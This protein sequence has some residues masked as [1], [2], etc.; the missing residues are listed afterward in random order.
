MNSLLGLVVLV[1]DI[2]ALI[3]IFQS[4]MDTTRK[5]IWTIAVLLFPVVGMIVYFLIGKKT[6]LIKS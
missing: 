4:S 1:L 6:P 5:V 2:V 3:D